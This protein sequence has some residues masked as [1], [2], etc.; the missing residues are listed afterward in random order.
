[1]PACRQRSAEI[2]YKELRR[3]RVKPVIIYAYR[4]LS[5]SY[6]VKFVVIE[7]GAVHTVYETQTR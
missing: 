4:P 1:M 7:I 5:P 2:S 3:A 6:V